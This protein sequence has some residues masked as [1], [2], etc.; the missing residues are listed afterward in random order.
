[1]VATDAGLAKKT[2]VLVGAG[3]LGGALFAFVVMNCIGHQHIERS[4]TASAAEHAQQPAAPAVSENS[5]STSLPPPW[6][7]DAATSAASYSYPGRDIEVSKTVSGY[8]I[9]VGRRAVDSCDPQPAQESSNISFAAPQSQVVENNGGY[10][11][12]ANGSS[13]RDLGIMPQRVGRNGLIENPPVDPPSCQG[14]AYGRS[15]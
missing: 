9:V 8:P 12:Y 4:T 2:F 15:Y 3:A 6:H 5:P 13:N 7:P 11:V 14:A 10:E 1:M